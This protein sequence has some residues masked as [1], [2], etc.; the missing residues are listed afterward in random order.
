MSFGVW[1]IDTELFECIQKLVPIGGTI[2]ELGSGFS[3]GELCKL[4]NVISIEHDEQYVGQHPST[5]IHAPLKQHKGHR[6]FTEFT[7]WYDPEPIRRGL[8]GRSYDLM[9]IDGP[10]GSNVTRPGMYRYRGLFNWDVPVIFDD[11][12]NH[13]VWRLIVVLQ[14]N[15]L[16]RH[17]A[18]TLNMH[19]RKCFTVL[20][21]DREV[22]KSIL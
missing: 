22:L 15:H 14:R 16:K 13:Q 6:H 9:L 7:T 2:L 20:H 3:T 21:P 18:L 8:E 11:S 17:A 5:Y 19:K 12:N 1:S 4:Y 10:P